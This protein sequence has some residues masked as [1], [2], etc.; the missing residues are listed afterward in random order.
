[1][2]GGLGSWDISRDRWEPGPNLLNRDG[3]RGSWTVC[4]ARIMFEMLVDL[5]TISLAQ[6]HG[7]NSTSEIIKIQIFTERYSL[8]YMS[9]V[10]IMHIMSSYALAFAVQWHKEEIPL[11]Y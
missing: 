6:V 8:N 11:F 2:V 7:L 3:N 4:D 9:N 1:M 10:S 5:W